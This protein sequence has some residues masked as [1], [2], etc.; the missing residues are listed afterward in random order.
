M[1]IP[2]YTLIELYKLNTAIKVIPLG[3]SV[4]LKPRVFYYITEMDAEIRYKNSK[5]P[6]ADGQ[7]LKHIQS[8]SQV[9]DFEV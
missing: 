5:S 9:H 7:N 8:K 2:I 3:E 4:I 1:T 6:A